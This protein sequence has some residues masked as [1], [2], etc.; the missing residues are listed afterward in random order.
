MRRLA[1]FACL[2]FLVAFTGTAAGALGPSPREV[3]ERA[4]SRLYKVQP[5]SPRAK[6]GSN[7]ASRVRV[8]VTLDDP[9]LATAAPRSAFAT[10]GTRRKLNFASSFSRSYLT[11]L[12]VAQERAISNVRNA[13]PEAR[14]SR[15]YQVLLNGFVVSVPYAKLPELLDLGLF[16]NVYPSYTYTSLLNRGPA[17]IGAPQFSGLTGAKGQGVK[18]AVVDDGVDTEHAFLSPT[19]L[20]YP[21]ASPRAAEARPRR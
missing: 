12:E 7:E 15:R 14:I 18:V 4:E 17:V 8:I 6:A 21:P 10:V 19:G 1:P 2:A 9:P 5:I 20:S 3:I 11:R 16:E 13:L